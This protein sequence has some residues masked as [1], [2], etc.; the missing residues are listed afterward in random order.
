MRA[1][2]WTRKR[3]GS[4]GRSRT[5][6]TTPHHGVDLDHTSRAWGQSRLLQMWTG[7]ARWPRHPATLSNA[8]SGTKSNVPDQVG[9]PRASSPHGKSRRGAEEAVLELA[10]WAV[11]PDGRGTRVGGVAPISAGTRSLGQP[12]ELAIERTTIAM[13]GIWRQNVRPDRPVAAPAGSP[14]A[15][16]DRDVR[17]WNWCATNVYRLVGSLTA[18]GRV[19]RPGGDGIPAHRAGGLRSS[20]LS[21]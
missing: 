17:R 11:W 3:L 18:S 7:G 16:D 4:P 10:G 21:P 12:D 20:G 2:A 6:R 8:S 1:P 9:S 13:P 5:L 19:P 15:A 14:V